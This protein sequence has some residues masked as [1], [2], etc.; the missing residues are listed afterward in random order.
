MQRSAKHAASRKEIHHG[1]TGE[2][3][4]RTRRVGGARA[5]KL[6]AVEEADVDVEKQADA[7]PGPSQI[8]Q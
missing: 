7:K 2:H 8:G 1:G 5:L 3:R 4:A 6:L